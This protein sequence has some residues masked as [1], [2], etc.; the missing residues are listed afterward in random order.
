MRIARDQRD[1]IVAHAVRDLPNECCGLI[2]VRD[3]RVTHV[4]ALENLAASPFRFEMGIDQQ[5]AID[6]IEDA[7]SEVGAMYHSHPR[8]DAWPSQTDMSLSDRWPG[9]EWVI[10]GFV[11][12]E[13][14]VRSFRVTTTG[15]EALDLEVE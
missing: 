6:E 5:R 15:V 4:I 1:A 12:T 13:P 8:T 3:G 7:G 2:G 9:L 11:S 10:V 14:V